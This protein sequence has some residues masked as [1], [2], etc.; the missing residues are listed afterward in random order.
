MLD[1]LARVD[2]PV[3][4]DLPEPP[5]IQKMPQIVVRVSRRFETN[6]F[7]AGYAS[8][9]ALVKHDSVCTSDE[10]LTTKNTHSG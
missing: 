4:P 10:S 3:I 8:S 2:L 5:A 6:E 7:L 9:G 1:E